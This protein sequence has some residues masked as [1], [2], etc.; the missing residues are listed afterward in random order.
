MQSGERRA[1]SAEPVENQKILICFAVKEEAAPFRK[2]VGSQAGVEILITGMG[3]RNAERAIRAALS[4]GKDAFHRVPEKSPAE[5]GRSGMRPYRKVGIVL[6]CGF[7]GGL[8]PRLKTGTVLFQTDDPKIASQLEAA[9]AIKGRFAFSERVAGTAAE[10]RASREQSGADAV[11]MES[12]AICAI[13]REHAIPAATVRVILDTAEED[14][15]LDFNAFMTPEQKLSYGRLML[16][17]ARSPG[18]IG[19]LLNLQK[20]SRAAADRLTDVLRNLLK[21]LTDRS[22]R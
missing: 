10:K 7:A 1:Q 9:G 8:D 15:P 16:A 2:R 6:T 20:Q 12:H 19:A 18:K 13:C 11:E 14:L 17:L 22:S 5:M 21:T 4:A 3:R